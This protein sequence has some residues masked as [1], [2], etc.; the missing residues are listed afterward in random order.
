MR[1]A[2]RKRQ[3]FTAVCVTCGAFNYSEFTRKQNTL[4]SFNWHSRRWHM[5]EVLV[6][7]EMD[8]QNSN[9]HSS[10]LFIFILPGTYICKIGEH[11]YWQQLFVEIITSV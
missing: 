11:N 9:G 6:D 2:E 10:F 1:M 8:D 5:M 7:L 4:V 3:R